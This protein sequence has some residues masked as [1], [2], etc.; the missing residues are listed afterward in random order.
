[1]T[2]ADLTDTP[3]VSRAYALEARGVDKRFGGTQAL[4]DAS[5]LLRPGT[6]HSLLGGNGSG[7]SS[8]LKCLAGVY[9]ADAGRG[10]DPRPSDRRG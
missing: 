2:S 4:D 6:V 1:M 8:M 5:L 7:K 9:R 3:R 10:H